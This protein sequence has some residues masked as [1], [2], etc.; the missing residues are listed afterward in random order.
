MA[1]LHRPVTAA[2]SL[3]G[4]NGARNPQR[5]GRATRKQVFVFA[6]ARVD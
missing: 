1:T 6:F 5:R 3:T 2:R 4:R